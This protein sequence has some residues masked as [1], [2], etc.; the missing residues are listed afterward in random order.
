MN[1]TDPAPPLARPVVGLHHVALAVS[2]PA[3]AEHYYT[4]TASRVPW[5]AAR[6]L[7]LPRTP[8]SRCALRMP[9]LRSRRPT[10]LLPPCG[11]R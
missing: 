4:A 6:A 11:G 7:G 2:E 9:G 5:P 3:R 8:P 1:G 10:R